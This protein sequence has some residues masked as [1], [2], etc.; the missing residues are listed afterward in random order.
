M[1]KHLKPPLAIVGSS[2][3]PPSA[4]PLHGLGEAGRAQWQLIT[5][6]Y[7]IDDAG[8]ISMLREICAAVD[9][10]AEIRRQIDE[11]GPIIMVR[12]MP[13]EHPG[14]RAELGY[15]AFIVKTLRA[16]GLDVEPVRPGVG[17][18]GGGVGITWRQLAAFKKGE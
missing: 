6:Q 10:L 18:P 2:P 13:R 7:A 17:R 14:L 4:D 5:S 11:D 15:Q 16:L 3:L 1:V 12:G 9:R 8:G